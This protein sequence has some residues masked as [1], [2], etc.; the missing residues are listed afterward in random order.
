MD[1]PMVQNLVSGRV[2]IL[3]HVLVWYLIDNC[4]LYSL[5]QVLANISLKGQINILGFIGCTAS[6][7]V[8]NYAFGVENS[9]SQC[10]N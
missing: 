10:V 9:H 5:G 4:V 6:V 3:S 1:W 7:T 8:A 2:I